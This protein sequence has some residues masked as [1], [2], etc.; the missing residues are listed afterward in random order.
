MFPNWRRW[1]CL[2]VDPAGEPSID[3]S[4]RLIL[5]DFPA[6]AGDLPGPARGADTY[7]SFGIVRAF[8]ALF[9]LLRSQAPLE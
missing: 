8:T 9:R 6:R 7:F 3:P 4:A 1:P 5:E 2:G